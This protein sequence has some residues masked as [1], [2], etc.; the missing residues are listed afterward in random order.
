MQLHFFKALLLLLALSSEGSLRNGLKL[1]HRRTNTGHKA[2]NPRLDHLN[3]PSIDWVSDI[4][5]HFTG[6]NGTRLVAKQAEDT[7]TWSLGKATTTSA[8]N[9]PNL[10]LNY[11]SGSAVPVW[12]GVYYEYSWYVEDQGTGQR[13]DVV[14]E[15]M[16]STVLD[17]AFWL[18]H[19]TENRIAFV[20]GNDIYIKYDPKSTSTL[21]Y[22]I[23]IF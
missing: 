9:D 8:P 20:Y 11:N 12:N 14:P 7:L 2:T 21:R 16:G 10:V 13:Y 17:L 22:K 4:E 23:I 6:S 18:P 19:P 15:G 3:R 1:D 5:V